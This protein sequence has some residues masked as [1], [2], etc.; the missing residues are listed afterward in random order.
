VLDSSRERLQDGHPPD[1]GSQRTGEGSLE[2][3]Y[4]DHL[5]MIRKAAAHACR[6]YGFSREEVEDFTQDVLVKVMADNY[7]VLRKHRGDSKLT[8]YL[9]IVVQHAA[10]DHAHHLW[11]KWRPSEEAKRHGQVGVQLQR[12]LDCDR[13]SFPEACQILRTNFGVTATEAELARIEAQLPPRLPRR[14][15]SWREG[16]DENP[17]RAAGGSRHSPEPTAV[18]GADER[19][20]KLERAERRRRAFQALAAALRALPEDEWLIARR[21]IDGRSVAQIAR[22]LHLD[23]KRQK[24]LYKQRERILKKLR[25]A[26]ESAGVRAE[27]LQEILDRAGT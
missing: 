9:V 4:L 27:D 8:T 18:E 7:A 16:E 1:S 10:H 25:Q 6:R 5:E 14:V 3:V 17:G 2:Q 12:L 23:P 26:M 20:W 21:L 11:G 24:Q 22:G 13:V 19:L 15:D